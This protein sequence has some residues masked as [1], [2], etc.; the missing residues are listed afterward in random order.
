VP[1]LKDY[2]ALS[3]VDKKERQLND[4]LKSI[5]GLEQNSLMQVSVDESR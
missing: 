3:F 4:K 5:S 1:A 2:K